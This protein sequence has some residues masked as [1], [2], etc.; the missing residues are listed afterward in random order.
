MPPGNL[1]ELDPGLAQLS[2][3]PQ[4]LLVPPLPA[5]LYPGDDPHRPP[6][7]LSLPALKKSTRKIQGRSGADPAGGLR[8]CVL[9]AGRFGFFGLYQ[10]G[11]YELSHL[12]RE[13]GTAFRGDEL[14][15]KPYPSGR[16]QHGA[17]DAAIA[18][19]R[20]L[21]LDRDRPAAVAVTTGPH[22]WQGEFASGPAKRRPTQI[23]E[24][25]FTLPFLIAVALVKGHVGIREVAGIGDPEVLDLAARI[26]GKAEPDWSPGR[27]RI[28]VRTQGGRSAA[29]EAEPPSGAPQRPL[30]DAQLAAKFRDCAANARPSIAAA[31]AEAAIGTILDLEKQAFEALV[32]LIA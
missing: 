29:R 30:S 24:A 1:A 27:L 19:H 13:L 22:A 17:R 26:E 2:Q 16:P 21:G 3:D 25:Q 28:A 4:L 5:P 9:F 31:S 23:V 14:S 7:C 32:P 12:T 6:R 18:L 10:P 15:F 11:G 8:E 20:K